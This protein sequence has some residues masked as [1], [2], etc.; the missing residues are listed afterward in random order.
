MLGFSF[1]YTSF[2]YSIRLGNISPSF[3]IFLLHVSWSWRI[4]TRIKYDHLI[5]KCG[6]QMSVRQVLYLHAYLAKTKHQTNHLLELDS[7]HYMIMMIKTYLYT[8]LHIHSFH[9]IYIRSIVWVK[10]LYE[11]A[12]VK[13]LLIMRDVFHISMTQIPWRGSQCHHSRQSTL[14]SYNVQLLIFVYRSPL[15]LIIYGSYACNKAVDSV[16]LEIHVIIKWPMMADIFWYPYSQMEYR[17]GIFEIWYL[18]FMEFIHA[19]QSKISAYKW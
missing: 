11:L 1:D 9:E 10:Q 2:L 6:L 18:A 19:I 5:L 13:L 7:I 16:L 8:Y 15:K 14:I 12:N 17:Y 4:R 3:A